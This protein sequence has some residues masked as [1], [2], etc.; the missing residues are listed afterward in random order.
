MTAPAPNTDQ[1]LP[2]V[3]HLIELRSRLLACLVAVLVLFLPLAYFANELY[4]LL[5]T[6][7]ISQLPQ[8]ASMIATDVTSPL[9][10]PLKFAFF[11]A[12]FLAMPVLLY[13]LWAFVSP[14]LYR[15][16]QRLALPLLVSSILLFYLG[17]AFAYFV[18]FPLVFSFFTSVAPTGVAV[19]TDI[20]SYL[21]FVLKLFFA[22]GLAF[23][24]PIAT[25]L[26]IWTGMT[27]RQ[28]LATKRPYIILAAFVLGM[29]LTPP[30]VLSQI[31]LALPMWL[32]FELGLLF[33]RF[34]PAGRTI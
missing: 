27:S 31:L 4:H 14:G 3:Q 32:L 5:A 19:M 10:A 18:V 25:V 24:V 6:P 22:F 20:S 11:L 7:L 12:L 21:S 16:E 2:L 9:L 30:D 33:S 13:H 8:G 29:L 15:H 28:A 26:V 1:P 23:E 34:K 17:T